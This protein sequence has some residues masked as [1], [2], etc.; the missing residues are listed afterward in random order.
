MATPIVS[1]MNFQWT[2]KTKP[3]QKTISFTALIFKNLFFSAENKNGEKKSFGALSGAHMKIKKKSR[4]YEK[5]ICL[6]IL[7]YVFF[8]F[9]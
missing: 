9:T 8:F 4:E 5:K 1:R 6:S 3:K 7:F 2:K